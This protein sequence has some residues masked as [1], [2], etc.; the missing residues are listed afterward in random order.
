[1][2]SNRLPQDDKSRIERLQRFLEADTE[3]FFE[4]IKIRGLNLATDFVGADLSKT[5]IQQIKLK[6][7]YFR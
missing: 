1:M 7:S 5:H 6:K 2:N 4:L 3:D